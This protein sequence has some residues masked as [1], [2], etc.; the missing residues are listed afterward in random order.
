ML[1]GRPHSCGGP[2]LAFARYL[3]D[4]FGVASMEQ[5]AARLCALVDQAP[6]DRPLLILSHN[7]PA[8]LG[9][10]RSDPCGRDF[11]PDEGDWGDPDLAIAIAHAKA[12]GHRLLAV[13]S[14]HMHHALR[15]GGTRTWHVERG[16]V[17]YVNAARVPRIF[18]DSGRHRRHHVALTVE[19]DA[20]RAEPVLF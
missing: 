15:G 7:G 20:A 13:V 11:H 3:R 1:A 5:S 17:L 4:A 12:Q 9:D 8:G 2:R 16:S 19:G 14:G 6:R 10:R 18:E